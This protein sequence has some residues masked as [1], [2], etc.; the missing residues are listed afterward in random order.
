M[1]SD[2]SSERREAVG[3]R[4]GGAAAGPLSLSSAAREAFFD[5]LTHSYSEKDLKNRPTDSRKLQGRVLV[6]M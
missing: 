3:R 5:L 1:Y 4:G 6:L 2:L